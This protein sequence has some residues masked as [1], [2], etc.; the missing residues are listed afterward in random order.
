[1]SPAMVL[2]SAVMSSMK[3]SGKRFF[4]G[5]SRRWAKYRWWMMLFTW[6]P[7]SLQSDTP[8]S[9]F[10]PVHF[11]GAVLTMSS[12]KNQACCKAPS[13]TLP[14]LTTHCKASSSWNSWGPG[15]TGAG[16]NSVDQG[17][18]SEDR[19]KRV[20]DSEC[21]IRPD[22]L[23]EGYPATPQRLSI[24]CSVDAMSTINIVRVVCCS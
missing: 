14:L 11:S 12:K 20:R 7:Q 17:Q 5:D 13:R 9:D 4:L 19:E 10:K 23:M 21:L 3:R 24:N 8:M 22:I 18:T 2:T 6:G 15:N 1:M 16:V